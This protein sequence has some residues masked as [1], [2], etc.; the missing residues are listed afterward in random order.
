MPRNIEQQLADLQK[1]VMILY[2]IVIEGKQYVPGRA[3]YD[4]AIEALV[5]GDKEPL[6]LF[7]QRGG[8]IPKSDIPYKPYQPRKRCGTDGNDGA[9]CAKRESGSA[10]IAT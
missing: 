8:E 9:L 10:G 2:S 7:I 4:R 5:N 1:T 3:E 6:A